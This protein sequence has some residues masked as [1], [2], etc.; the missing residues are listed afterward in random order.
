LALLESRAVKERV[1]FWSST[2]VA[3]SPSSAWYVGFSF[4]GGGAGSD[5]V[6]S[7]SWVRCVR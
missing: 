4:R 6:S 5:V 3:D 2:L 1:V 7:S